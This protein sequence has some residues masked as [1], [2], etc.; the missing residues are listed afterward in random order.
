MKRYVKII[1]LIV[2]AILVLPLVSCRIQ[3]NEDKFDA[4]YSFT[5]ATGFEV[6]LHKKPERVA[7]LFSSYA[8]MWKNAGGDIAITVGESVERGFAD[9]DVILVDSGAG[10]TIN[11]ELLL[12]SLPAFVIGSSDIASHVEA[13]R[14]L[15]MSRIPVALFK[16]E[17]FEDY[18]SVF[19]TLT[20]ITENAKAYEEFAQEAEKEVKSVVENINE[21]GKGKKILFMRA[22]SSPSS[23]KAKGTNDHFAAAMLKELGC[24]NIADSAPI[25][26]DSLS[27]EVII[28]SDPEYIFVSTMGNEEAAIKNVNDI[29]KSEA[30]QS[31][32][33]I[34]ENKLYFLPKELFQFKPNHLW[35]EAY[36]YLS[37]ILYDNKN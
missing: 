19:K 10:K 20:D 6:V 33:A 34:K 32:T 12:S 26:L 2:C 4:I 17:S 14:L 30:W 15:K 3:N 22:G 18:L 16:V 9:E 25:L 21:K 8:Q 35:G 37:E 36:T 1:C 24:V 11:T 27:M 5:D 13:A 23:T 29:I 28:E 7:V 31:L